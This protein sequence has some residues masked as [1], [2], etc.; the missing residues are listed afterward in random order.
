VIPIVVSIR[1]GW[2]SS[3]AST[4]KSRL[5]MGYWRFLQKPKNEFERE[6]YSEVNIEGEGAGELTAQRILHW[7]RRTR[8]APIPRIY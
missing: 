8:L 2:Q 4:L 1:S 6:G 3:D 7:R 5:T